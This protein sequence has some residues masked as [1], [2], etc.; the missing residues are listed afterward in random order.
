MAGS[1]I[2]IKNSNDEPC[3]LIPYSIWRGQDKDLT[4][5]IEFI[6][7][8]K[9]NELFTQG[10][11]CDFILGYGEEFHYD[12]LILDRLIVSGKAVITLSEYDP[13][14]D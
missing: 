13:L 4:L 5:V 1:V 6:D 11:E 2:K 9:F 3:I 10:E 8:D 12:K 14:F 7:A